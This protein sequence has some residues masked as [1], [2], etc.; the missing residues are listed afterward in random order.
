VR[1]IAEALARADLTLSELEVEAGR[2]LKQYDLTPDALLRRHCSTFRARIPRGRPVEA[3]V[4]WP[5]DRPHW[6]A[7]AARRRQP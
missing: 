5:Y 6:S 2:L 3:L 4:V 7:G 1:Q